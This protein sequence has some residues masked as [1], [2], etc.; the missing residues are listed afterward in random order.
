MEEVLN[1]AVHTYNKWSVVI[2][3]W[4]EPFPEDYLKYILVWIQIRN[5]PVNYYTD[6][7]IRFL[8][9]FIREVKEVDFDPTKNQSRD[10]VRARVLFDVSNPVRRAKTFQF[11]CGTSANIFYDFEGIRKR[12]FICQRLTHENTKCPFKK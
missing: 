12:C 1:K 11:P 4:V 8:G 7:S 5:I 3:K 6:K 10:Y 2:E 9:S